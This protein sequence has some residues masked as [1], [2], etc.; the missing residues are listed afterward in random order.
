LPNGATTIFW[1]GTHWID[2]PAVARPSASSTPERGKLRSWLAAL[3]ATILAASLAVPVVVASPGATSLSVSGNTLPG[4]RLTLTGFSAVNTRRA[5]PLAGVVPTGAPPS[6]ARTAVTMAKAKPTPPQTPTPAQGLAAVNP[7]PTPVVTPTSTLPLPGST[8]VPPAAS[9][10]VLP[11]RLS[12]ALTPAPTSSPTVSPTPAP[13]PAHAP[14]S[15]PAPTPT[16]AHP[17]ALGVAIDGFP[18]NPAIL[19]GFASLIGTMP[20]I[21]HWFQKWTDPYSFYATGAEQLRARGAMPLISWAPTAGTTVDP[22]WSLSSIIDGRH[23]AYIHQ[24]THAA[25]AWGH[26]VYVRLMYEMNGNWNAW[27]YGVNGNTAP[28]F[29]AAWRHIVDIARAEG[30]TNIRW[31]WS[32]NAEFG[33]TPPLGTLAPFYPGDAYVDWVGLDGYNFGT[34]K[35]PTGPWQSFS[36]VLGQSYVDITALTSKPLMIGETGCVEQGG[37]KAAWITA[38]FADLLSAMPRLRAVVWFSKNLP[39][40]DYRVDSSPAALSAYRAV[41]RSTAF[42]GVLP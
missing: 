26:P 9:T 34:S 3:V 39:P 29:V 4:A 27:G 32:P 36:Q 40:A 42:A 20:R 37:D 13:T 31:V 12:P 25:A 30:A 1:N 15:T 38:T 16:P 5:A 2:E 21:V 22:Q 35:F 24:W 41:A 28:Q 33:S 19:D 7:P 18:G 14:A 23:D 10:P 17:V 8:P 6:V 11:A